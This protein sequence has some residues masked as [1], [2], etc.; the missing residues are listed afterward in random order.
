MEKYE[1]REVLK[2]L[3]YVL[4]GFIAVTLL[5]FMFGEH[6]FSFSASNDARYDPATVSR[7]QSARIEL[8]NKGHEFGYTYFK[9]RQ[10]SSL[11]K[12]I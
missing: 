6:L 9:N 1:E 5:L 2:K 12:K 4:G 11:I 3:T 8:F 7:L 10:I